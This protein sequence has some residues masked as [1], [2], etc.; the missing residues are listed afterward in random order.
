MNCDEAQELFGLATDMPLHDLKRRL[1]EQHMATCRDCAA[2]FEVWKESH[3]L[4]IKLQAEFTEF[5]AE[6]INR[7]VMD[8]IYRES[9]W[10]IPDQGQPFAVSGSTR[11][12]F[13]LW[14]AGFV[15]VFLCSFLYFTI[16]YQHEGNETASSSISTG[17]I[18]TGIANSSSLISEPYTYDMPSPHNGGIM[19]PLVISMSPS[20]PQYWMILSILGVGMALFSLSRVSKIRR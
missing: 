12:R 9:P 11:K 13:S 15:M 16:F 5:Q 17:I 20:H 10:L 14:I 8:R 2:E 19:D 3:H 18:P 7:N 6:A 1:F 4:I